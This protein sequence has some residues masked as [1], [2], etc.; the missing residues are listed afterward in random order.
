MP[1][2][3]DRVRDTTTSVGPDNFTLSGTAPTAF[4]TF[5]TAFAVGDIFLVCIVDNTGGQWVTG[6]AYLTSSTNLV[7]DAAFDGSSGRDTKVTFSAGSKDV[8]CTVL[9]HFVED[10]DTGAIQARI[11][12]LAMP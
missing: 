2:F 6:P 8:F 5:A 7:L 12:G 10:I 9:S 3:R 11:N 4:Q 1:V